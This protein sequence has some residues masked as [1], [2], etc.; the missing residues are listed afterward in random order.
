MLVSYY[1]SHLSEHVWDRRVFRYLKCLDKWKNTIWMQS[2]LHPLMHSKVSLFGGS[3]NWRFTLCWTLCM[4]CLCLQPVSIVS[5]NHLGNN[6]GK[7]LSAP[8]QFRSKEVSGFWDGMLVW[9]SHV[10]ILPS[11]LS[12]ILLCTKCHTT[13]VSLMTGL[14]H[15][16]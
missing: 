13:E 15:T 2:R 6:D 5:Y 1:P 4:C 10:E 3:D 8:K 16:L 11:C 12:I 7:N 14:I 9:Q